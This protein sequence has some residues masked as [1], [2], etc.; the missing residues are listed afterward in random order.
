MI[1][2]DL[3]EPMVRIF[4][5]QAI[6]ERIISKYFSSKEKDDWEKRFT[7]E[8]IHKRIIKEFIQEIERRA[9]QKIFTIIRGLSNEITDDIADV[10]IRPML[11][12]LVDRL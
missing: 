2:R 1:A 4:L 8:G 6:Y 9:G 10:V 3:A 7:D 12:E 5:T 11:D